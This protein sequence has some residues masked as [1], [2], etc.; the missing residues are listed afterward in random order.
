ML[1]NTYIKVTIDGKVFYRE[2]QS[3]DSLGEI[4]EEI[5]FHHELFEAALDSVLTDE[6]QVNLNHICA[7]IDRINDNQDR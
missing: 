3:D 7:I 6:Y 1:D 5:D 2:I 4:L